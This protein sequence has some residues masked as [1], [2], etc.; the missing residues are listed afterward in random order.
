MERGFVEKLFWRGRRK[1]FSLI[2]LLITIAIIAILAAV[3]LPALNSARETARRISCTSNLKQWGVYLELYASNYDGQLPACTRNENGGLD[4][5]IFTSFLR[6]NSGIGQK[7]FLCPGGVRETGNQRL[8]N[9]ATWRNNVQVS[10]YGFNSNLNGYNETSG[11]RMTKIFQPSQKFVFMDSERIGYDYGWWRIIFANADWNNASYGE[12][13]NRH[14]GYVNTVCADG[15]VE[16]IFVR[17]GLRPCQQ[18]PFRWFWSA[19]GN[20]MWGQKSL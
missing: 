10:D 18:K 19:E 3:L 4:P 2:E 9:P 15:H 16:S 1:N 17:P 6:D 13:S 12:P 11:I 7:I 8:V 20:R 5:S 14:K